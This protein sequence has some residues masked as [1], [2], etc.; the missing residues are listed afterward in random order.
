MGTKFSLF[1]VTFYKINCWNFDSFKAKRKNRY[2]T[3]GSLWYF[4][5]HKR[6]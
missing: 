2:W 6:T 4:K 3:F 1:T 5:V